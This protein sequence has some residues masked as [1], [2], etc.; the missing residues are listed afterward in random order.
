M[1]TFERTSRQIRFAM[2][3]VKD[4]IAT[5]SDLPL[6]RAAHH[7][8]FSLC[9]MF[10]ILF[11][12][13]FP[14]AIA[15][16]E[17]TCT[18]RGR[19]VPF[20]SSLVVFLPIYFL[21]WLTGVSICLLF[22]KRHRFV[23]ESELHR[24]S[25]AYAIAAFATSWWCTIELFR[26]CS[27]DPVVK[28]L[29]AALLAIN[30]IGAMTVLPLLAWVAL[31]KLRRFATMVPQH[32]RAGEILAR[33]VGIMWPV[34]C[35]SGGLLRLSVLV[36]VTS[37]ITG[38]SGIIMALSLFGV[39]IV[40]THALHK[41][42]MFITAEAQNDDMHHTVISEMKKASS[43]VRYASIVNGV[44]AATTALSHVQWNLSTVLYD[45][46]PL[47]PAEFMVNIGI[48]LDGVSNFASVVMLSGI[49]GPK[50]K[51][52]TNSTHM[53]LAAMS[54]ESL[55]RRQIEERFHATVGKSTASAATIAAVLMGAEPEAVIEEAIERFRCIS[56][57]SL[58]QRPDIIIGGGPLSDCGP[59]GDDLYSLSEPCTLGDC[60]VFYSH[61]WHDDGHVKWAA[62][63]S[64]CEG[65]QRKHG[66]SPRLWLDKVCIDQASIDADL[67][68]LPVFLAGCNT[69]FASS[70]STYSKR[71][72]CC[73]ELLIY[74]A[75]LVSDEA[76]APPEVW[77]LGRDLRECDRLR[78]MW[79][80]FDVRKSQCFDPKDKH[81]FLGVVQQYPGGHKGFNACV[82]DLVESMT[83]HVVEDTDE[84]ES[85]LSI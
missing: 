22:A 29:F 77:L 44:S 32:L 82:R 8:C 40:L 28:V 64:W 73:M 85:V 12:Q 56:W 5:G 55:R 74:K 3:G 1:K 81:R 61:S 38:V 15:S 84:D 4:T 10:I 68:C 6:P 20:R 33:G 36:E 53:L 79:R 54:K 75:M 62:L 46:L 13:I 26:R 72:W 63:T 80:N 27:P 50:A 9:V 47:A 34:V 71:L 41:G 2:R 70:G 31:L 49:I 23:R 35:L 78:V 11:T 42:A 66:R 37:V 17:P 30:F 76:R 65:F 48:M 14:F 59:A 45:N 51:T 18:F 69:M 52:R 19:E 58:S 57:E 60:D 24:W 83:A 39:Q 16:F 25:V 43:W 21:P 67:R 7:V